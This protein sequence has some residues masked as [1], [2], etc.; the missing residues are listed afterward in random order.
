MAKLSLVASSFKEY[1]FWSSSN[2][3][4][5]LWVLIG[6]CSIVMTVGCSTCVTV[7]SSSIVL[8]LVLLLLVLVLLLLVCY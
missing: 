4:L 8:L 1:L 7:G 2:K 5:L 6:G 3:L